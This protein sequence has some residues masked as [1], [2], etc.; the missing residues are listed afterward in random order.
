MDTH[1]RNA[2]TNRFAVA[3]VSVLGRSNTMKNA[4]APHLVFQGSQPGIEFRGAQEDVH[5]PQYN[6]AIVFA[7]L[8]VMVSSQPVSN[9]FCAKREGQ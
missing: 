6:C 1:F 5:G 4:G 8:D 2:F 7:Q 3:E 9:G